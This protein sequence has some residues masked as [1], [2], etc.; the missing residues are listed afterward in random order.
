MKKKEVMVMNLNQEVEEMEGARRATGISSTSAS[1]RTTGYK[2]LFPIPRF[3]RRQTAGV[4]R[5]SI[6]VLSS[7]RPKFVKSRGKLA[8]FCAGKVC[9]LPI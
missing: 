2:L 4:I 7:G 8:P 3:R 6:N 5:R 9:I 1:T